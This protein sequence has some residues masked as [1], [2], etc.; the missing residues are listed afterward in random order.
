MTL[1]TSQAIFWHHLGICGLHSSPDGAIPDAELYS[2]FSLQASGQ[3]TELAI[4]ES[5]AR[6]R[7]FRSCVDLGFSDVTLGGSCLQ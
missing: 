5:R 3:A 7:I 6:S 1:F 2:E 4:K